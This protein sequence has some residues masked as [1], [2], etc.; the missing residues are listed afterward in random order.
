M[1]YLGV[2]DIKYLREHL[3]EVMATTGASNGSGKPSWEMATESPVSA[4]V[5]PE[6]EPWP[7]GPPERVW[8][9]CRDVGRMPIVNG[10]GK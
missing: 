9:F 6:Y 7:E 2:N 1:R 4:Y 10:A 3:E 8:K 5:S